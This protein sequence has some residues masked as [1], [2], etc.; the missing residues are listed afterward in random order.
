MAR[1]DKLTHE[2]KLEKALR[3]LPVPIHDKKHGIE[4]YCVNDQ[5]RSNETRFE[6]ITNKRHRLNVSDI[7]KIPK[8]INISELI[9][10]KTRKKTYNIFIQRNVLGE[11][12]QISLELDF[13]ESNKA[14]IKTI[15]ISSYKK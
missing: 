2:E 5:A 3:S 14:K 1:K 7:E 13:R 9:K 15:F 11:F 10:D 6:H 8:R 12:I 4:I